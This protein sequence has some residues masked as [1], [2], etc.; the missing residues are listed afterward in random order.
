MPSFTALYSGSSGNASVVQDG[1]RAIL[2]DIGKNCKQTC[3]A[4]EEAGIRPSELSGVFITHEHSDHVSGLRVFLKKYPIPV[5]GGAAT[6]DYLADN[7][8]VPPGAA[9]EA[10]D[11]RCA[12][13]GGFGV[14][15]FPTSHDSVGCCGFR[16]ET[17]KGHV[18]SL[19]TDLGTVD[20][21]V[22]GNLAGADLVALEA[23]YD[24]AMLMLGSY[25]YYLKRRIASERGHLC[26]DD[27]AGVVSRLAR[28]GCRKFALC[29][30]S[31]ENNTPMQALTAVRQ[32]LW[33][34]G[35][36]GQEEEGLG[37][38]ELVACR[39]HS[40]TGTLEF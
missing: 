33:A 39:R 16:V 11:G 25:P 5:Y 26:N 24:K 6:L 15:A 28:G 32:Q 12:D 3:L 37:G 30:L 18:L 17:E 1:G 27:T 19:A 40:L 31:Q 21:G 8:M 36:C 2:I 23:N 13:V 34:D 38:L 10:I 20:D 14:T 4:L 22:Y 7:G 35:W 9:M 29:H